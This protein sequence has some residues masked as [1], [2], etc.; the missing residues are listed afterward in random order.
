MRALNT[1]SVSMP[2]ELCWSN[3]LWANK[4]ISSFFLVLSHGTETVAIIR[5]CRL[6]IV[7]YYENRK[8]INENGK[9]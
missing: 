5:Y 9:I 1:G 7:D 2:L 8:M 3:R 4:I 6:T